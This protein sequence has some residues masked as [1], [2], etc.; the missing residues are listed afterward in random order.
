MTVKRSKGTKVASQSSKLPMIASKRPSKKDF[1]L[2]ISMIS[3]MGQILGAAQRG[4]TQ[5]RENIRKYIDK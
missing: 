4:K 5:K 2:N 3:D 1:I